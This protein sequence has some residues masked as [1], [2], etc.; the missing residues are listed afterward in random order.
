MSIQSSEPDLPDL[1]DTL[2]EHFAHKEDELASQLKERDARIASLQ[3]ALDEARARSRS[4]PASAGQLDH[5]I[6]ELRVTLDAHF[7]DQR[8]DQSIKEVLDQ[9]EK[10]RHELRDWRDQAEN[11]GRAHVDAVGSARARL[12]EGLAELDSKLSAFSTRNDEH[13]REARRLRRSELDR[14]QNELMSTAE[15][16]QRRVGADLSLSLRNQARGLGGVFRS[17]G[18]G[19]WRRLFPSYRRDYLAALEALEVG[20]DNSLTETVAESLSQSCGPT[21]PVCDNA[22][23]SRAEPDEASDRQEEPAPSELVPKPRGRVPKGQKRKH[24][25]RGARKR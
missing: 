9:N 10:L 3:R 12:S 6:E 24:K 22:E 7:G 18:L 20:D 14:L 25:K 21:K 4:K 16:R 11:S 8:L 13:F 19:F 2:W 15:E 17:L 23:V 5:A 1:L